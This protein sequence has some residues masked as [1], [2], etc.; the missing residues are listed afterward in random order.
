LLE[1]LR[2]TIAF[3]EVIG[4]H[5]WRYEMYGT[6]TP[7]RCEG[8]PG[9]AVLIHLYAQNTLKLHGYEPRITTIHVLLA[10]LTSAE[11]LEQT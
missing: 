1:N 4:V 11:I 10:H 2:E 9:S 8:P 7:V 3:E 5:W 6:I